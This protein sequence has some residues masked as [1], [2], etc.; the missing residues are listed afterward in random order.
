MGI[1]GISAGME[2][3][4]FRKTYWWERIILIGGGLCLV[5][6]ETLTDIV[7]LVLVVG[8]FVLQFVEK[9]MK[10]KKIA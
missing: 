9:K 4:A 2:G 7:G 5:V 10:A 8:I 6:P 3:Y 1:I